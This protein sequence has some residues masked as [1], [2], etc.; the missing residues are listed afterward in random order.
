MLSPK[1]IES[2]Q[3]LFPDL[4]TKQVEVMT[5]HAFGRSYDEIADACNI[6]TET[7]RSNLKRTTKEL[8]LENIAALR[9]V[10]LTRIFGFLLSY[11]MDI[12]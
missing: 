9:S 5:L 8:K 4:S 6:S 3:R 2:V 10:F 12:K 11:C 7:V 1:M